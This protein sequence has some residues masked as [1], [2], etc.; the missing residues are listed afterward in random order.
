MCIG[1]D[2]RLEN[3]CYCN[4]KEGRS[5]KERKGK[6]KEGMQGGRNSTYAHRV[7]TKAYCMNFTIYFS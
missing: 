5:N 1:G 4:S 2:L 6:R 3:V 7:Y